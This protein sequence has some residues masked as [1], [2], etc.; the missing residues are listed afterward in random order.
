M[1]AFRT[2]FENNRIVK[3]ICGEYIVARIM[4]WVCI[5][6]AI[7]L[8]FSYCVKTRTAQIVA[9]A[10]TSERIELAARSL[11]IMNDRMLGH[12]EVKDIFDTEPPSSNPRVHLLDYS[13]QKKKRG[14]HSRVRQLVA[15]DDD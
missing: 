13:S 15:E 1:L 14:V 2:F 7:F 5:I 6:L 12:K 10:N 9:A 8:S 4:F 3:T 11:E